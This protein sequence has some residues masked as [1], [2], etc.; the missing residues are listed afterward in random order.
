MLNT[1]SMQ[2]CSVTLPNKAVSYGYKNN[3]LFLTNF[4]QQ[5]YENFKI[6][7]R[8]ISSI[9]WFYFS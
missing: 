3:K 4:K 2:I 7:F 6:I 1:L 8:R 9:C 5:E